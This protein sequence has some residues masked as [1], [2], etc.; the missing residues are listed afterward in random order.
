MDLPSSVPRRYGRPGDLEARV[1]IHVV[2]EVT[3][4]CD[5]QCVHC[6]SRAGRRRPDELSTSECL[7]LV[8]SL[9]ALGVREISLIG[10]EAYL[11]QDLPEIVRA[12]KARGIYCGIQ[13]GGRNLSDTRLRKLVN[14]GLDGLGVSLD[15]LAPLH[16]QLR[17]VSGSFQSAVSALRKASAAG[18]RTSVNTQIGKDTAADLPALLHCISAV[19]ARQWQLQL[20]VPMGNAADNDQ[21]VMQPY[22]LAELMSTVAALYLEG[23]DLGVLII[24]GNNLGF[25]GPYE[26]LLRG[27]GDETIYWTGCKAGR[28]VLAI[29]ADGTVKGCPSLSTQ[30]YAGGNVRKLPVEQ[31]WTSL[32][33]PS[34]SQD[35]WGFCASC[36]YADVCAGGCT[37]MTHS[38]FGRAGNNPFC[39][40][41]VLYLQKQGLRER[42]VKRRDAS[43]DS[44]G[45]GEF[46]LMLEKSDT[47]EVIARTGPNLINISP[48]TGSDPTGADSRQQHSRPAG[49]L[50][51]AR[52]CSRYVWSHEVT[53][54]HCGKDL[55]S[56][57]ETY[58]QELRRRRAIINAVEE[59]LSRVHPPSAECH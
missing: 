52:C 10:G 47:G 27:L 18:L 44:F 32:R 34:H 53:C 5:L 57:A 33:T 49:G 3:L 26:Y 4:A 20:T 45:T 51:L 56:A 24:V 13:T 41:R 12:I 36:Y 58:A 59:A 19:G 22:Q 46:D 50:V 40:H 7:A 39:H 23:I 21:L 31:L 6:G 2:W 16:D 15:G 48:R 35:L 37:W 29:E 11:R 38:L 54:P 9:A 14:A 55:K 17:G 28:L 1:P 30:A 42:I 25:F 43:R 8:D